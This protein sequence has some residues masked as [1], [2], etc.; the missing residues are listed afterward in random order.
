METLLTVSV[1]LYHN[2][3]NDQYYLQSI[4]ANT[5]HHFFFQTT[6]ECAAHISQKTCW[7]FCLQPT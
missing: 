5:E 7:I 2:T 1:G 3:T 4:T 6:K